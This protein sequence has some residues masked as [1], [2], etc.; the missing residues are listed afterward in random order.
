VDDD[1][2]YEDLVFNPKT[3]K[4]TQVKDFRRRAPE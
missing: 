3:F 4:E 2:L 1:D